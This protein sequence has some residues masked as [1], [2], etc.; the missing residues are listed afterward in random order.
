MEFRFTPAQMAFRG[1]V[2][3]FLKTEIPAGWLGSSWLTENPGEQRDLAL[4]FTRR[5]STRGWLMP[6]WPRKYGGADLGPI[7]SLIFHEEMAYH[8]APYV[9]GGESGYIGPTVYTFG[10]EAQKARYL[11][12]MATATEFWCQ[13]YSEPGTGSDLAGLSTTAL[14]EGDDYVVNGGKVWTTN[15]HYSNYGLLLART[16]PSVPKHKGLSMF[17]IDMHTPGIQVVPLVNIGGYRGFCQVFFENARIPREALLGEE[18]GGWKMAMANLDFE[19]G[20]IRVAAG[21]Q[22]QI[23]RIVAGMRDRDGEGRDGAL[24]QRVANAAIEIEVAR[25]FTYRVSSMEAAGQIPN[26]EAS[27]GKVFGSELAQR[28]ATLAT[29][30]AGLGGQLLPSNAPSPASDYLTIV[31][32]TIESGTS[33]IQRNIIATRG[34]G[35]P[36]G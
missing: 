29:E 22:R 26:Y 15:G 13:L 21:A 33:E 1:E 24:W 7:E 8:E 3:R 5:L 14:R 30:V 4:A 12:G 31:A 11:P 18:N 6:D 28:L 27:V 2:Q 23:E 35:L 25:M 17:L 36:R 20:S 32:A 34:L 19:R 9:M 16:D 10:S